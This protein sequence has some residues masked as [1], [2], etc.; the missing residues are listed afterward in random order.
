ME[1]DTPIFDW[2]NINDLD[3]QPPPLARTAIWKT[4][5]YDF[6]WSGTGASVDPVVP[7]SKHNPV[8]ITM[9][10]DPP[11][12]RLFVSLSPKHNFQRAKAA[13]STLNTTPLRLG[14]GRSALSTTPGNMRLFEINF[15]DEA[16]E[17]SAVMAHHATMMSSYGVHYEWG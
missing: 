14:I 12:V 10:I 2:T 4:D 5:K 1:D 15:W 13:V 3:H 7:T 9:V 6:H 11:E 16:L 8:Y 17:D